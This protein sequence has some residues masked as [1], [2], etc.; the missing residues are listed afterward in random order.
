MLDLADL[1]QAS[2]DGRLDGVIATSACW[3]G[4]LPSILYGTG[5]KD[6][7]DMRIAYDKETIKNFVVAMSKWFKDGYYI[8]LQNHDN[9]T[10]S[11]DD[12]EHTRTLYEIAQE[13]QIPGIL[14]QDS[15]YV[16][17][18]EQIIHD[19]MK[20][21]MA[22]NEEDNRFPGDG[23]HL[24]D[25]MWMQ[26]HH[27]PEIYAY[28]MAGLQELAEKA[29][30]VIPELDDYTLQVPDTTL[31][32]NPNDVLTEKINEAIALKGL[33]SK[34]EYKAR[35]AE[36]MDV[37]VEAGFSGYLLFTAKVCEQMRAMKI[38]YN[39]RGSASGSLLCWLL[40][41]T[42]FDPIIWK[43]SFDR[44][45]SKDRTK[46]P[47]I[48]ID[49]EHDKR[50]IIIEWLRTNYHVANIITWAKMGMSQDDE[51]GEHKGS[52]FVQ[53]KSSRR[54]RGLDPFEEIPEETIAHMRKLSALAPYTGYGKH[55]AGLIVAPSQE[56]IET[57]PLMYI[58]S[59]KTKVTG[60]DK[61][62]IEKMGLLKLDL[63]GLKTL[64]AIKEMQRATGV[65][66]SQVPLND[67][68]VYRNISRG[69]TAGLFQLE[70]YAA[71][72]G[73]V[74]LKPNKIEDVIAAMALFRPATLKSGETNMYIK[75]RSKVA[76][77]PVRHEVI[78]NEVA[79]TYGI[80]LYQEQAIAML[81][82]LDTEEIERAR[83]AI[84]ASNSGVADAK[85]E[86]MKIIQRVK[87]LAKQ[88]GMSNTDIDWLVKALNAYAEY[89]F[90]KAHATS[91]G[92]MAYLTGWYST[93]YPVVF[94][95]SMLNAYLDDDKKALVYLKAAREAGITIK[96]PNIN[97]SQATY[98]MDE[99]DGS[100]RKGLVS[101]KG[102]GL[103]TAE[104]RAANAP[105]HTRE[106]IT[107]KL[108]GKNITGV[109]SLGLGHSPESCGGVITA[110]FEANALQGVDL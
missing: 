2:E 30:V 15:H 77:V 3:F 37:I 35:I 50:D 82:G 92:V 16:K 5:E 48:D 56:A 55:A 62:D 101:V 99:T 89:G 96:R 94:W 74:S 67:K 69:K 19:T 109:K 32:G 31:F 6:K 7:L 107:V 78:Q 22:Y 23:Y 68:E 18:D 65:D 64:S 90:N 58:A 13:L 72:T 26:C 60:Y 75:R 79:S 25:D 4:F 8:E 45:L 54:R 20:Q 105:Y 40:D 86:M 14:T 87:H 98:T 81:N 53:W 38:V 85:K 9:C 100:I 41:I 34:P 42:S 33:D 24:V 103:S 29:N 21:M 108:T 97:H 104:K 70:G 43:L 12:G 80:M 10:E 83:K 106:D 57:V 52:I 59:S 63:L 17:K 102:V 44:F 1:A 39:I 47:D 88:V 73:C 46:P 76:S 36:E 28:G 84:K 66:I 51:D 11:Q 61:D 91:Y 93:H 49:I 95:V 71:T 27:E 110:L